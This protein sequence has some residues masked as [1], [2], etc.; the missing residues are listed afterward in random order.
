MGKGSKRRPALVS[1]EE[2]DLR[3]EYAMGHYNGMLEDFEK[4][5]NE[6]RE[7]TGL[8]KTS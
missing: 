4:E 5:I 3:W 2:L 8:P 7:R 6:I 1:E